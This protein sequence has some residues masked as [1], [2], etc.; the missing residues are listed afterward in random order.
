M[1]QAP[2]PRGQSVGVEPEDPR[3]AASGR[4]SSDSVQNPRPVTGSDS[5]IR[6]GT[7]TELASTQAGSAPVDRTPV[8][9]R[10]SR[11]SR[12]Y[13]WSELMSR[14]FEIDVLQCPRCNGSP[15]RILAAIHPPLTTQAI[16][17][18]L[19]LPARAPPISPALPVSPDWT[20]AE[21]S[22]RRHLGNYAGLPTA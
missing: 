9:A 1:S 11:P 6:P 13:S 5:S 15:M 10:H 2:H 4:G 18:S 14:V 17:K 21:P 3:T 16:L 8:T 20:L 22:A 7:T 19:G 12:Y